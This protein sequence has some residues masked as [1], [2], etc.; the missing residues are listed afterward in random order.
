MWIRRYR[1]RG[2]VGL[3]DVAQPVRGIQALTEAEVA[4]FCGMKGEVPARSLDRLIWIAEDLELIEKGRVRRSTL[5]RAL[6]MHQLSARRARLAP[7]DDLDRFEADF[8]NEMWQSDMLH[9]P[10]LPDPRRPK[11]MRRSWLYAFLDDHSLTLL[12]DSLSVATACPGRW[13]G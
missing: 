11:K 10:W 6:A 1:T 9:G 3:E 2:L 8:P 12:I 7:R 5:H 4:L 13:S